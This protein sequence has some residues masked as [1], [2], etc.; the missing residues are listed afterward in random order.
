MEKEQGENIRQKLDEEFSS[1]RELLYAVPTATATDDTLPEKDT[2]AQPAAL[3]PSKDSVAITPEEEL[4]LASQDLDYDQH[5]RELAFD[6]RSKPKDRTKSEEELALEQ[7]EALEKAERKRR[8]RMMGPDE[9]ESEGEGH[10][11]KKRKRGGDD[12]ED[13]FGTDGEAWGSLGTGLGPEASK[14]RRDN[15]IS[16]DG[17][18][19]SGEEESNEEGS[20][21]EESGEEQYDEESE[22]EARGE[23]GEQEEL[24]ATFKSKKGHGKAK[25]KPNSTSN[26]ELPY[27]FSCPETHDDFLEIIEDVRDSDVPIVVQRI[28]TLHHTSLAPENKFKLQALTAVLL[29]HILHITGSPSPRFS[30]VSGLLPHLASLT[31]A[32]P[33]RSAEYFIKKLV[34]MQKNL[35][36]GLSRGP[37]NSE[38]KT[39]PGPSELTLLR[40]IG[41]LWPTSDLNHVV[42]SPARIL[43]GSYLGLCRVRSFADLASGLFLCTLLL[44]Y[45]SLSKRFVPEAINFAV[46]AVVHL[47]PQG[48]ESASTLPGFFPAP[49]FRSDLHEKLRIRTS[50]EVV[51]PGKANLLALLVTREPPEQ[52]KMDLLALALNILGRYADMYK[53]LEGFIE[54]YE[55]ILEIIQRIRKPK[56]LEGLQSHIE[57]LQN[58]LGRLLKFARQS[59]QP[60]QLQ[61]H[62]PIP[63]PTYIPKFE[64]SSSSYMRNK[65]PDRERN[66]AA[67]LRRQY[68]QERKGAIRELRK[69]ARFLAGVALQKQVEKDRVYNERMKRVFGSLEGERAEE[70]AIEKQKMKEKRRAGRK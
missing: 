66:E 21:E 42:I 40:V 3:D 20:G 22:D 54:L 7:K 62:K 53:A 15:G 38:S 39:W 65:D 45:E 14:T 41:A 52:D 2:T 13:D 30:L 64:V 67:K 50:D 4:L 25:E 23:E 49:D 37:L 46:N 36:H 5:V 33:V 56:V 28:R 43:M 57:S 35:K 18:E 11:S 6:K 61:S 26:Q 1:L 17:E 51:T 29:D 44:Q 8:R 55:P 63:I 24:V 31:K 59:R 70:K 9:S 47:A 32:Y 48:Y 34:L 69:D 27:T 68:K 60:L 10:A 58:M 12:L 19:G 16:S